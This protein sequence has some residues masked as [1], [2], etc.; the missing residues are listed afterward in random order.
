[1]LEL[2]KSYNL[3]CKDN[4][5]ADNQQFIIHSG[6]EKKLEAENKAPKFILK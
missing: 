3:K 2:R 4:A 6:L 1:M 5:A